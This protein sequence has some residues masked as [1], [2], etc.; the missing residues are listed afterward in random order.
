MKEI[1]KKC[2]GEVII[3]C[4]AYEDTP[5]YGA[6]N[7]KNMVECAMIGGARVVRCCWPQDIAA[8]R[9]LSEDRD[10]LVIIGINKIFPA[11]GSMDGIFITP[12]FEAAEEIIKAGADIVALDCRILETRGKDELLALLKKI[13][14]AYPEVGVMA[15]CETY[16]EC[17]FCDD[18]GLVDIVSTT[19][20]GINHP[21]MEGPDIELLKKCKETLTHPI[22]A[23]GRI[24]EL[25]DITAVTKENA[26]MM[27]IGTAVTRPHLITERF[28]NHYNKIKGENA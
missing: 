22:N 12:T 7:M 18:T 10:K 15:D 8:A 24:W 28:I 26:D 20:S 5:L 9:S 1:V 19:L 11:D 14:E 6:Q 4:Q 17:K 23:E 13:N 25:A 27:T 16:E 21:E 3:S 2:L